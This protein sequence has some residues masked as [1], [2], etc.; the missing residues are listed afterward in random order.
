M[1]KYESLMV[2]AEKLRAAGRRAQDHKES[3]RLMARAVEIEKKA[4]DLSV[5]EGGE[6]EE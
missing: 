4:R 3:Q 1:T 2:E 6:D 5:A